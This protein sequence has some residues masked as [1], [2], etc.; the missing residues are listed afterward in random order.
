MSTTKIFVIFGICV[1]I[2]TIPLIV[3]YIWFPL[4]LGR[5]IS[6]VENIIVGT[7]GTYVVALALDFTL[8]R[9]Q[10]KAVIKVARIALSEASQS[11]NR[12]MSFFAGM[13]KA[14]SD[15]FV[16]TT[17]EELFSAR[18][19]DLIFLHLSL[20]NNAP[21]TPKITWLDHI[22]RET[23]LL[24]DRLTDIQDRYQAFLPEGVL[25]A[26][27]ILRNNSLFSVFLE[28]PNV[29]TSDKQHNVQRPVLN[30]SIGNFELLMDEIVIPVKT[31]HQSALNIDAKIVPKFPSSTF[32]DDV[33]PKIGESRFDGQPGPRIFIGEQPPCSH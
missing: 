26:I 9:R 28:L 31:I 15:G 30:I 6:L 10:E 12:M 24:K 13:I 25:A 23:R 3:M 33:N 20:S 4:L 2:L 22:S 27:G 7:I 32:R 16:P 18:S 1:A 29:V 21:V 14:S 19:M 5:H 17:I 11:I 8:R